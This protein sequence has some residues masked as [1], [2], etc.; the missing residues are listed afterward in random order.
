[1]EAYPEMGVDTSAPPLENQPQI[2][3]SVVKTPEPIKLAK[4]DFT[5]PNENKINIP[6]TAISSNVFEAIGKSILHFLHS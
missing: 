5:T 6:P 1:M 4:E 2:E 3:M